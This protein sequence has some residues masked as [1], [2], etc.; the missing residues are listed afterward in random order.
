[1]SQRRPLDVI[2]VANPCLA[3]W[4]EM[5]GDD[6]RRFCSQ[7]NKFVHNLS[8]MPADEAERLVCES[9]GSLCARFARDP[10]NGRIITLDYAPRPRTSRLR[11]VLVIASLLA[12]GSIAAAWAAYE[13]FLKPAPPQM[14]FVAGGIT[15]PLPPGN[16]TA[17]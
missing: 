11:A 14:L 15:A 7:C 10:V 3:A 8:A 9:A 1:M 12:S 17:P 6:K 2:Q 13:L 16:P 5:A 4:D